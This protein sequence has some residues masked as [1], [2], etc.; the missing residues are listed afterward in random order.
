MCISRLSFFQLLQLICFPLGYKPSCLTVH[1]L[2]VNFENFGHT[3][4]NMIFG[5]VNRNSLAK[6]DF[7]FWYL[8][9]AHSY[10]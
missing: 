9:L 6:S 3:T 5:L 1:A 2:R 7:F 4:R 10:G 8:P